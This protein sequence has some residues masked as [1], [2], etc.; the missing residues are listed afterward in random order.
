LEDY[1]SIFVRDELISWQNS[2]K[3][4]VQEYQIRDIVNNNAE[5]VFKKALSMSCKNERE[6]VSICIF[7]LLTFSNSFV[8]G[9]EGSHPSNQTL[10][11]LISQAGNPLKLAQMEPTFLP[12]L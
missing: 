5:L 6:K 12:M 3:T 11:D 2:R 4:T 9:V 1:L 10:L 8:Q 7:D